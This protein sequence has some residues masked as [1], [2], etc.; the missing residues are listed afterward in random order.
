MSKVIELKAKV[1]DCIA[2]IEQYTVAKS[3][4]L[5]ELGVELQKEKA[6]K[7]GEG[8]KLPDTSTDK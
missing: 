5:K 2:M 6:E 8:T 3:N 7:D 4:L 1:F